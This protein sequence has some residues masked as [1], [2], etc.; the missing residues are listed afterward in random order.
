MRDFL[1]YISCPKGQCSAELFG[2]NRIYDV[3]INDYTESNSNP[4]DAEYKFSTNQWKYKHIYHDL[5]DIVFNYKAIAIFDDDV[6]ITT[7]QIN[8]LFNVGLSLDLNIWQAALTHDSYSAWK[9]FYQKSD[10]YIRN[11]NT[12]EVMMPFFNKDALIKCWESFDIN[13]CAWG[14]DV[15]WSHILKNE[16]IAVIDAIPVS[17]IRPM[18]GHTRIMPSGLTPSAEAEIVFKYYNIRPPTLIY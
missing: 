9:H 7:S 16:K 6:K 18:R 11:T 1:F 17:H 8:N 5:A 12:M 3:A 15:A 2:E 10:S 13:Y 14:L 4:N